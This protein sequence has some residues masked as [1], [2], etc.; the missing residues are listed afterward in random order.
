MEAE[1]TLEHQ[2]HPVEAVACVGGHQGKVGGV[3]V[4][5]KAFYR[6][7]GA[8]RYLETTTR[9]GAP[10]SQKGFR[11][12]KQIIQQAK[13]RRKGTQ[14]Q[15]PKKFLDRRGRGRRMICQSES[16]D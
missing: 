9:F 8:V 3:E 12:G 2:A 14:V 4:G 10:V 1:V 5:A 6:E 15:S 13:V 11:K 16:Q 7:E